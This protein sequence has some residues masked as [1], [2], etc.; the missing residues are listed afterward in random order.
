MYVSSDA[1]GYMD[2]PLAPTAAPFGVGAP[3]AGYE[4]QPLLGPVSGQV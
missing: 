4:F 1:L 3:D 2:S